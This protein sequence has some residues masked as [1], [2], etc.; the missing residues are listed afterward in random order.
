MAQG[1]SKESRQNS[2]VL[3]VFNF[4]SRRKYTDSEK[5]IFNGHRCR[6]NNINSKY[7][8]FF[9]K[10]KN[11]IALNILILVVFMLFKKKKKAQRHLDGY[12]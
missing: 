7:F 1:F 10:R 8:Y 12:S 3:N 6:Q 2:E 9:P 4:R 11:K 5:N